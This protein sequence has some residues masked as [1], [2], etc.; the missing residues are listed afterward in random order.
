MVFGKKVDKTIVVDLILNTVKIYSK[1]YSVSVQYYSKLLE[2][3]WYNCYGNTTTSNI[4]KL[5][6]LL[7]YFQTK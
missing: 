6:N 3:I 5:A 7:H 2:I 4:N 1:Y